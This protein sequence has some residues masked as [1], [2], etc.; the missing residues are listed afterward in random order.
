LI[1]KIQVTVYIE[2]QTITG[3]VSLPCGQRMSYLLNSIILGQHENNATFLEL[4]DVTISHEDGTKERA[5]TSFINKAAIQLLTTLEKDLAR[6]IGA[7]DG[8]KHYPYVHKSPI[9]A[10]MRTLSYELTGDMHCAGG[11]RI[12]Q[13]LEE[14]LTFLP[15]TDAR[16]RVAKGGDSWGA[17][18]VAVNRRQIFS[19]QYEETC[20]GS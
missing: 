1:E 20:L 8:L 12:Q 11:Q 18:F 9:R 13:L 5:Q 17:T 4:T 19:L 3:N 7:K 10:S 6:G 2:A 14:E 16:I 15:L